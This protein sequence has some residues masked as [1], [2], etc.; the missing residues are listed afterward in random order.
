MAIARAVKIAEKIIECLPLILGAGLLSFLGTDWEVRVH[1]TGKEMPGPADF[2]NEYLNHPCTPIVLVYLLA[3]I[4][5]TYRVKAALFS[6]YFIGAI[7]CMLTPFA[8]L[9][10]LVGDFEKP[11]DSLIWCF[12]VL[13]VL[14]S[15]FRIIL[16]SKSRTKPSV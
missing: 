14:L 9:G 4:P 7:W 12:V 11:R 16:W 10:R 5:T 1:A 6:S 15:V 8:I 3:L 13:V 2:Y